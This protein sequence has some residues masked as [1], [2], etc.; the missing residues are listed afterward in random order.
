MEIAGRQVVAGSNGALGN[1]AGGSNAAAG[2]AAQQ[3]VNVPAAAGAQAQTVVRASPSQQMVQ[4]VALPSGLAT[5]TIGSPAGVSSAAP[6]P[7]TAVGAAVT[8]LAVSSMSTV[9]PL[10]AASSSTSTSTAAKSDGGFTF[11]ITWLIPIF[12][13][14]GIL[15]LMTIFG[16]CWGMA[17]NRRDAE[18]A[19][20]RRQHRNSM[21]T[22]NGGDP[23]KLT[24]SEISYETHDYDMFMGKG[25]PEM[26]QVAGGQTPSLAYGAGADGDRRGSRQLPN[27]QT[28]GWWGA[29][30]Q[31]ALGSSDLGKYT[32]F[33][34]EQQVS[35]SRCKCFKQKT[36][37]VSLSIG[38]PWLEGLSR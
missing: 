20:R 22:L 5:G 25:K 31:R 7:I 14:L 2:A 6:S 29:T 35:M 34:N 10:L 23:Q 11:K 28:N 38:P 16:K 33:P 15:L 13:V 9:S 4:P 1:A 30:K 26:S 37:P 19:E 21:I 36:Q 17:S 8:G 12:V 27:G 3:V 18:E 24:T 32:S